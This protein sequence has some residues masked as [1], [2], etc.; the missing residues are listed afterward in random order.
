MGAPGVN[1]GPAG[2][3]GMGREGMGAPGTAEAAGGA[4]EAA[5]AP[6]ATKWLGG[7]TLGGLTAGEEGAGWANC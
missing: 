1:P 5:G 3:G 7:C 4:G 2:R 6:G